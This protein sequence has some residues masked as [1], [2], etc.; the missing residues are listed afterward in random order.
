MNIAIA[1]AI[2]IADCRFANALEPRVWK[3]QLDMMML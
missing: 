3:I 1:I 2:A